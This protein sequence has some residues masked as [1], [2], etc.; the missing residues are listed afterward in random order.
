[1]TETHYEVLDV[2]PD[3]TEEEIER[4]YRQKMN[5]HHP[6][7]SDD[8]DGHEAVMQI[9][10]AKETLLDPQARR[11]YDR[12]HDI[13][14]GAE[15]T[16][17]ET[18]TRIDRDVTRLIADGVAQLRTV[19]GRSRHWMAARRP[20]AIDVSDVL[21]SPTVVRLA[22]TAVFSLVVM[23]AVDTSVAAV[24]E[25]G[26]VLA[27]LCTSYVGYAIL[28]PLPFEKARPR[29]QFTPTSITIWPVLGCYGCGLGLL[30]VSILIDPSSSG[31]EYAIM[32]VL[33]ALIICICGLIISVPGGILLGRIIP[34]WTTRPFREVQSGVVLGLLGSGTVLFTTIGGNSTLSAFV[35]TVGSN[36][37]APWLPTFRVGPLHLGS[38][39]NFSLALGLLFS[40]ASGVVGAL[41][42][43]TT[44]P[45]QDRYEYGYH[46]RPTVWNLLVITPL[47]TSAWMW[48]RGVSVL[49]IP[50]GST[51]IE[52]S[53]PVI[54][55]GV[56]VVLPLLV[57]M[58]LLRR[59][60]ERLL[61][62]E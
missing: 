55:G 46:V 41:W 2:S 38:L 59:Q 8:P 21:Y 44:V 3:A 40:L 6:D 28:S 50:I 43:L 18:D 5:E 14:S 1:M 39:L 61:D 45:W 20:H 53:R 26:V 23:E 36:L 58:Y 13:Q 19:P 22:V 51:T 15:D 10:V 4:A 54:G 35:E 62:H 30:W 52:L 12:T 9:R 17:D 24:T 37:G 57:S 42:A 16:A 47:V 33:Y 49:S 7:Q 32:T 48:I 60:F 31:I 11:R 34:F 29:S 56:L 25:F 27:I